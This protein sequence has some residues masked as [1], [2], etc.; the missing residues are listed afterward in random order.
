MKNQK[1]ILN[2]YFEQARQQPS[3]ISPDQAAEL[4]TKAPTLKQPREKRVQGVIGT[5]LVS[6]LVLALLFV[7]TENQEPSVPTSAV[8]TPPQLLA[9][10]EVKGTP[11]T[12]TQLLPKNTTPTKQKGEKPSTPIKAS[13]SL[14][15]SLSYD[16]NAIVSTSDTKQPESTHTP[17]PLITAT[18]NGS[19]SAELEIAQLGYIQAQSQL[20]PLQETGNGGVQEKVIITKLS[21]VN[22]SS[23]DYNPM[24]TPDGRT[25][26]FIS[27]REPGFG[28]H[29]FWMATKQSRD[30]LEFTPPS[31]L[32]SSINTSQNEGGGTIS[33]DG[34]TMYFT[35]CNRPDGL[36]DCDIY[37]ARL[38]E[39]G[40]VKIRNVN[41][42]N[43]KDW[44]SQPTISA[45]GRSLFFV[46]NRPGALGGSEDTDIYFSYKQA[47]GT[48]SRP[49]NLG[50]PVN[51]PKFEDSPFIVPSGNALYFS[52]AGHKGYGGLDFFVSELS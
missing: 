17:D 12:A 20:N 51:T 5:V 41:E 48:W 22:S 39:T 32:G 3:L 30:Q 4:L 21:S 45:D 18:A 1:D 44:E 23:N 43:T 28:G 50:A 25:L 19:T 52:S 26:Y 2:Q 24:I 36:G 9:R 8:T 33:A 6:S 29:D 11:L 14:R 37:E 13:V 27:G 31:N 34:Q 7:I 49:E 10:A 38:E 40:W 16:T 15:K 35:A 47:D 46:S 42:I